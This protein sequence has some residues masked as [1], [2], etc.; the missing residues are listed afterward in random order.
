[1]KGSFFIFTLR[2]KNDPILIQ[3]LV[4]FLREMLNS[5]KLQFPLPKQHYLEV[6]LS[7]ICEHSWLCP[8][9]IRFS[10]NVCFLWKNNNDLENQQIIRRQFYQ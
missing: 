10:T 7:T 1:M 6:A 9:P 4:H 3:V 5:A 8:V 2:Q